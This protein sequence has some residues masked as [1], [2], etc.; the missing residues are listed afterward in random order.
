[1]QLKQPKTIQEY[2]SNRSELLEHI[3]QVLQVDNRFVAAWLTG[4]FG[5]GDADNVS[6]LDLTVVV[7]NTFAKEL[8]FRPHQ[9]GATTTNERYALLSEFGQPHIIHEN[10]HN[11]PQDGTFT[12]VLYKQTALAID[13]VLRPHAKNIARPAL[14]VLL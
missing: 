9:V 1:M 3:T 8:C 6:D 4:S 11:A 12:F 13:W 2:A 5:R 7:E 10:H 14:S